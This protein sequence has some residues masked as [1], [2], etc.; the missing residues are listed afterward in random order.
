M[1]RARV[2]LGRTRLTQGA[3]EAGADRRTS[4]RCLARRYGRA[5]SRARDARRRGVSTG[6]GFGRRLIRQG[7]RAAQ[8]ASA[9]AGLRRSA[10]PTTD[11]G[12]RADPAPH[13]A[14]HGH[15]VCRARPLRSRAG[16]PRR[17]AVHS[18]E[19]PE[20][21]AVA[22]G[23]ADRSEP[24]WQRRPQERYYTSYGN[25]APLTPAERAGRRRRHRLGVD[26]HRP[27]RHVPAHRRRDRPRRAHSAPDRG[28]APR[29]VARQKVGRGSPAGAGL[30]PR[31]GVSDSGR[32]RPP[33]RRARRRDPRSRAPG[34]HRP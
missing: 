21:R 5:V 26:R 4:R 17:L 11:G 19:L 7:V 29:G 31:P 27:R 24:R 15:R 22:A 32:V 20:R 8:I 28:R 30:S 13:L 3:A 2:F 33:G 6:L 14:R 9:I 25:P 34:A 12:H 1:T 10:T 18:A 16:C 23:G